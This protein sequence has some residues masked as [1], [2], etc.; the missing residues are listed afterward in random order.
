MVS[1]NGYIRYIQSFGTTEN[2]KPFTIGE[3]VIG[4]TSGATAIVTQ[5]LISEVMQDTGEILYLENRE[6]VT[7]TIDQTDNLHLVIEF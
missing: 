6:L 2:Y 3:S 5:S 4:R 7:R 1:G